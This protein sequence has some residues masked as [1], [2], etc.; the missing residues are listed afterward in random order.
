M[1]PLL[2]YPVLADL[3]QPLRRSQQKTLAWI[4][5]AILHARCARTFDIAAEL[6]AW[7]GIRF[8]SALNR[9][10]RALR[11]HRIDWLAIEEQF[12]RLLGKRLGDRLLIA[13]DWTEWHSSMRML[14]AS[15]VSDRRAIPVQ[16]EAFDRS[17]MPRS[18]NAR[19]NAFLRVLASAL[20]SAGLEAVVCCDRGFR[21]VSWLALLARL[22]FSFVVRLKDDVTVWSK[23]LGGAT[24]LRK[25][26]LTPESAVDLGWVKL[27]SSI[28]CPVRIVGVWAKDSKEPWWLATNLEVDASTV[29]SYYDRRMAVEEQLR[30]QKGCRFGVQL[31]WTQFRTPEHL[32]RFARLVGIALFIWMAVGAKVARQNPSLRMPHP[33]KG[34][35]R[36]YVTIGMREIHRLHSRC[37]LTSHLLLAH[38]PRPV[39]RR[40]HWIARALAPPRALLQN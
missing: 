20:R 38:L 19:E 12:L 28:K 7:L 40:F 16:T 26:Q 31:Y 39:L 1:Q 8:D 33:T 34:P 25:L 30:D 37:R 9:L 6:A 2:S 24:T 17:V 29:A 4:L 21:R 15:V 32:G 22:G 36:S 14:V 3:L 11:N 35:R 5:V 23:E 18:Q 10:Y 27:H 13:I